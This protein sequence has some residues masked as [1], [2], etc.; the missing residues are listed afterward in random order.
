[1]LSAPLVFFLWV[2]VPVMSQGHNSM[3]TFHRFPL[4]S[5]CSALCCAKSLQSCLTLCDSTDCSPPGFS[6]HGILQARMLEWVP[7]PSSRGSSRP[8][9]EPV[10]HVSCIG[11]RVLYH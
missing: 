1:M 5:H 6:V 8:R 11:R 4:Y 10:S 7:L 2:S 3:A 9:I